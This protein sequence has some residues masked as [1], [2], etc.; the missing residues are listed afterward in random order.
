MSEKDFDNKTMPK[1][2]IYYGLLLIVWGI[3]V[4][5]VSESKSIT[6]YA[7]TILGIPLF[8]SGFMSLKKPEKRKL[9]MHVAVSFGLLCAIGGTR[10]FS[11][12]DTAT[13]Y[14]LSSMLMLLVTGTIYTALCIRSFIQARKNKDQKNPE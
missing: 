4:S 6:S 11:V 10:F 14:A 2:T 8:V 9:W 3:I 1:L 13:A 5:V 12:M 7:P